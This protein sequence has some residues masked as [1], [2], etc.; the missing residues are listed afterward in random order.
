MPSDINDYYEGF[1][2]GGALFYEIQDKANKCFLSDTNVDLVITYNVIKKDLKS[3]I[4]RL[5]E[6][7]NNHDNTYYYK[8]RSQHN[9]QE[10]I[11]VAARFIYMNKTCF[12]GLY[13]VNKKGNFNVP[14][15]KYVN[16][17]ILQEANLRK[18]SKLLQSTEIRLLDFNKIKPKRG[19]FV[20]FDPPYHPT[21][22]KSFTTYTKHNFTEK[23]QI[24]LRDFALDLTKKGV[25]VMLS[26][27]NV[28]FIRDIYGSKQ[29][30]I[31]IVNAPRSVNCKPNKRG[32]VEEVLITNY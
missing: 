22:A 13:R 5:H 32:T 17:G 27:S 16:P 25:N 23:D 28:E 21:D 3:L 12:N 18:V 19:D 9:L 8:V 20:Y 29:F 6:H 1:V 14:A 10:P 7:K 31:G 15:G 24:R 11:E 26:N 30:N 2:G 4:K